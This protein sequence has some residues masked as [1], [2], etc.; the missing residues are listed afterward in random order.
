MNLTTTVNYF[1]VSCL[2]LS[3]LRGKERN[4]TLLHALV[5]Q[6]FLHEP[7]LAKFS[8][9]LTEFKAVSGGKRIFLP[10]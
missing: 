7:D 6:I 9:E 4:F 5:E 10:L 2:Q 1:A 8:Q 3:L